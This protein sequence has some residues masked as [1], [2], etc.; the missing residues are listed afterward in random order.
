MCYY[1]S[2]YILYISPT[3]CTTLHDASLC[4][5][6]SLVMMMCHCGF[7]LGR[8]DTTLVSSIDNGEVYPCVGEWNMWETTVFS[9]EFYRKPRIWYSGNVPFTTF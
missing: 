5:L 6:F 4:K 1:T 8:K 3:E 9:S 2:L 7:T